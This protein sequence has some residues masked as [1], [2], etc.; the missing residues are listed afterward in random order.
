MKLLEHSNNI[1]WK[2]HELASNPMKLNSH[3]YEVI[4]LK[5]YVHPLLA[6]GVIGVI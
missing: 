1:G 3:F 4:S 2:V 5:E 6:V